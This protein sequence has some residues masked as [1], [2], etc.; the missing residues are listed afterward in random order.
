MFK[1]LINSGFSTDVLI[2]L[3]LSI[4]VILLSLSCH[5]AAHGYIAYKLGDPTARNLGRLTLNPAKHL[6]PIGT[7]LMLTVG[8]GWAKPVPIN[9]RNFKDPRKGMAL[10][11]LAGPVSNFILALIG[12]FLYSLMLALLKVPT[13]ASALMVNETAYKLYIIFYSLF[14]TMAFM[15]VTLAVFNLIPLPPFDG[16]RIFYVFLPPKLYFAVMKYERIILI[17]FLALLY[18]GIVSLPIQYITNFIIYLFDMLFGLI[19]GLGG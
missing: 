7:I 3:L 11:A 8:Y 15:N 12:V 13:V 1:Q 18:T 17:V 6:D 19:F 14:D 5:E 9:T 16:S 4:P 10:S 2:Q